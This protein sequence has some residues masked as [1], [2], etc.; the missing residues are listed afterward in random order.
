MNIEAVVTAEAG[1]GFVRREVELG[2]PR[3]DEVLVR[4]VAAGV[5]HTDLTCADGAYPVPTP[6]VLGHEGA[7][8]VEQVGDAVTGVA[9]GDHVLLSFD[10][11]GACRSCRRALPS[12]C[13]AFGPL[14]FSGARPDGSTSLSADGSPLHSHFFGQSSFATHAVVRQRSVVVV[15]EDVPLEIA[16]PLGCGIQT[17]AGAVLNTLQVRAGDTVAV[18]GTGGVGMS[19]IMAAALSG[20][21]HVVA[22]DPVAE[23]RDLAVELGATATLD[24]ASG[25]VAEALA[26]LSGG[27]DHVVDTSGQPAAIT[28][29]FTALRSGGTVGMIG[30]PAQ[31]EFS[32]DAYALLQ[33]KAVRGLC[34]GDAMPQEFLPLLLDQ[35]RAGRFPFDRLITA[36]DFDKVDDAVGAM[37]SHSVI[38]PVLVVS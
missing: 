17:G 1:A 38:K 20:A 34:I 5:C 11:C 6:I 26:D 36:F 10:S 14:N 15:P 33:G 30:G 22:I 37:R 27:L 21:S 23:R 19:A 7:G 16:A 28:A 13:E 18:F 24:P 4:V 9:V 12:Y 31:Q 3:A 25:N 29:G 8:I 35:W 32:F 2:E